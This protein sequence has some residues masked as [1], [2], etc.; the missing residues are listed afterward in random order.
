[1]ESRGKTFAPRSRTAGSIAQ[2]ME[3]RLPETFRR[4]EAGKEAVTGRAVCTRRGRD[5]GRAM[6]RHA[7]R[8][9]FL[10]PLMR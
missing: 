10:C 9:P 5:V 8:K 6:S 3:V 7:V 4:V 1:M 2:R